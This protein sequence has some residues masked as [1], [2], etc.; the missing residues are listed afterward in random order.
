MKKNVIVGQSGGPTAVINCSLQGGVEAA[1][2]SGKVD[3]IYAALRFPNFRT[4][5]KKAFYE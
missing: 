3:K 4:A 2:E 5:T 1:R